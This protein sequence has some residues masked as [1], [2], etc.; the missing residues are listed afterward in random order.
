MKKF[1]VLIVDDEPIQRSTMRQLC[2]QTDA[3]AHIQEAGDAIAAMKELQQQHYDLL[4]LDINMPLVSGLELAKMTAGKTAI[5]FVTAYS[6]HAVTAFELE[7]LDYLVKPVSA[8]RLLQTVA[9]LQ[10]VAVKE[11]AEAVL[12][13]RQHRKRIKIKA[14]GLVYCEARGNNTLVYVQ[15]M[16]PVQVYAAFTRFLE[17]LPAG[18]AVRIHR[19]FAVNPAHVLAV[20]GGL[21]HVTGNRTL[22][23][24]DGYREQA[25]GL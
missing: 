6:E 21:V 3:F 14:A 18:V 12:E 16:E 8:V 2:I 15:D 22:P 1:N 17:E 11:P 7:A 23:I 13:L 9:K 5:A 10:R 4:L 20:E 24:G 19:S 25:A